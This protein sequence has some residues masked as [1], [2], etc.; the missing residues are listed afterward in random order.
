MNPVPGRG[1]VMSASVTHPAARAA[2][3]SSHVARMARTKPTTS[4]R[5]ASR[6]SP[7]RRRTS[8]TP[9]ATTAPN[10]G[11]S[12]IAPITRICESS[13]IAMAAIVVASA[14]N[15]T[16]VQLSSDSAYA[17]WATCAQTTASVLLP[18]ARRSAS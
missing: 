11:P 1:P 3:A 5:A 9:S 13:T 4:V 17:R 14:M 16:Y 10:S 6:R 12:T 8:A 7:N 18:G 15:V 2:T